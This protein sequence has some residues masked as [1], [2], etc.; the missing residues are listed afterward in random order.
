[1]ECPAPEGRNDLRS[2]IHRCSCNCPAANGPGEDLNEQVV[3]SLCNPHPRWCDG[4]Y[5]NL[6]ARDEKGNP[7]AGI[8][9]L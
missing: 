4:M 7:L 3:K 1:M 8:F 2:D 5:Q 6:E 9:G